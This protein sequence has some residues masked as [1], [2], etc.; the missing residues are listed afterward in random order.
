MWKETGAVLFPYILCIGCK[1]NVAPEL[2]NFSDLNQETGRKTSF[3][4][5]HQRQDFSIFVRMSEEK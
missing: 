4:I 5:L 3:Q 2:A 1:K